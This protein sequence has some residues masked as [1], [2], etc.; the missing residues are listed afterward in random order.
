[1]TAAEDD[2]IRAEC[3]EWES[4]LHYP[5]TREEV[6]ALYDRVRADPDAWWRILQILIAEATNHDQ[7]R[8]LG[9][10][11]LRSTLECGEARLL[12]QAAFIARSSSKMASALMVGAPCDREIDLFKLFGR[13]HVVEVWIR[14][15]TTH[16]EFDF[17]AWEVA[18][19]LVRDDPAEAW[20]FILSLVEKAPNSN[21]VDLIGA[22]LA[23]D[24]VM[25]HA[26]TFIDRIEEE[27]SRNGRFKE[28]LASVWI[29]RLPPDLFD[30]IERAAGVPLRRV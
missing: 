16:D 21:M 24:F 7:I 4:G 20:E 5:L 2:V 23:E 25:A 10:G 19:G 11:P 26:S 28:A 22:G 30:R 14:Y 29:M 6:G 3:E 13:D 27:A 18:Q 12:D 9:M 1:M 17:W 15:H 8:R